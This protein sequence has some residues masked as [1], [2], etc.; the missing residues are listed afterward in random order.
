M[1]YGDGCFVPQR[2][3][4][5]QKRSR[6]K[7]PRCNGE[8]LELKISRRVKQPSWRLPSVP[9]TE[10]ETRD[11]PCQTWLGWRAYRKEPGAIAPPTS[12]LARPLEETNAS[13]GEPVQNRVGD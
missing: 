8:L 4:N 10:S 12:K 13:I 5:K 2:L 11:S 7:L 6:T 9:P 3:S 1:G